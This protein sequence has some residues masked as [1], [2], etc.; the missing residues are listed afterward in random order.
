[1]WQTQFQR[2]P[3]GGQFWLLPV[4]L[5]LLLIVF[6][7]LIFAIPRTIAIYRGRSAVLRGLLADRSWVALTQP[8]DLSPD[9]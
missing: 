4:L 9:G 8:R 6:G 2:I 5:G 7:L 1:M 3:G